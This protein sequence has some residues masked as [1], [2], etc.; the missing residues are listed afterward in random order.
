MHIFLS[1]KDVM[2][3]TCQ[4]VLMA[5]VMQASSPLSGLLKCYVQRTQMRNC[6][7]F[8]AYQGDRPDAV[9]S[10]F[11]MAADVNRHAACT[12]TRAPTAKA[13]DADLAAEPRAPIKDG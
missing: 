9:S 4:H 6:M 13:C 12:Q 8:T 2:A 7:R 11:L 5:N 1:D 10:R 3:T